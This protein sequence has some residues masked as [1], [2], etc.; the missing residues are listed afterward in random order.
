M[1]KPTA[2]DP[3]KARLSFTIAAAITA[4]VFVVTASVTATR[5]WDA[6]LAA[7]SKANDGVDEIKAHQQK[8][9]Q[10]EVDKFTEISRQM[11]DIK[12]EVDAFCIQNKL[13]VVDTPRDMSRVSMVRP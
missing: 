12:A 11:G 1:T 7:I 3:V 5:Y 6:Q 4:V 10:W 8:H 9:E 13:P 2:I